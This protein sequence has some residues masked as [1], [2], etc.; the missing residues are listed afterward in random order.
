ML[1]TYQS[2]RLFLVVVM[3]ILAAKFN[4]F[5]VEDRAQIMDQMILTLEKIPDPDLKMEIINLWRCMLIGPKAFPDGK[6]P[7]RYERIG[8][9]NFDEFPVR[10]IFFLLF[11]DNS[12]FNEYFEKRKIKPSD[13]SYNVTEKIYEELLTRLYFD[14]LCQFI[15][16]YDFGY[17]EYLEKIKIFVL[18]ACKV[19]ESSSLDPIF[20]L[21]EKSYGGDINVLYMMLFE[22]FK[23]L[24]CAE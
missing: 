21:I 22:D 5:H 15:R 1:T 7:E 9:I 11:E 13:P 20:D 10:K 14:F 2:R 12:K 19:C 16:T 6:I 18:Y 17:P 23:E 24:N 3:R 4:T 8:L